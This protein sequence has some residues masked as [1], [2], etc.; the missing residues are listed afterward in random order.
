LLFIAFVVSWVAT[1]D[2]AAKGK[3]NKQNKRMSVEE[4]NAIFQRLDDEFKRMDKDGDGQMTLAEFKA[5]KTDAKAAEEEFKKA[6]KDG[7]GT[8]SAGEYLAST[9]E[10]L[11]AYKARSGKNAG[12]GKKAKK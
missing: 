11:A 6:D 10:A 5:G 8:V 4:A 3:G 1:A 9:P 12:K 7:N 2:A